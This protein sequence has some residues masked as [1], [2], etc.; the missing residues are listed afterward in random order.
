MSR[1]SRLFVSS[2]LVLS[3]APA[4]WSQSQSINGSISGRALDP[5]GASVAGATITVANSAV[6]FSKTVT[7]ANDGF[8]TLANLP[9][10]TYTVKFEASGFANLTVQNVVLNAGTQADING[11]L[12]VG[13]AGEEVNVTASNVG[14]DP[15]NL[16]V[17]RTLDSREVE[18]MPLTSRNPYNYIIFQPGVSGHPNPELG[19]PRTINTNGL[20]D[21]INYQ[22]DGMANTESDRTGLR[23]F[24]IGNIFVKEVQT[25]S[26]SANPEFGWTTGDVYNVISNNGTNQ[27]HGLL[28]YLQRWQTATAYPLLSNGGIKPDLQLRDFSGNIGGPIIKDKLFFFG[29]YEQIKRGIP[30]P[31]TINRNIATEIG[32]G[33]DQLVDAPGMLNGKFALG[34]LDWTINSKNQ[35]MLRYNYFINDFPYNTQVGGLNAHSVGSNFKDRAHV[36]GFQLIS[37]I[38]DHLVNEF[39]ATLPLRSS[40][41]V[42]AVPSNAPTI[43]ITNVATFGASPAGGDI[44]FEKQPSGS[45]NIS[46]TRGKHDIK[47]GFVLSAVQQR[48]RSVSYNQYTFDTKDAYLLAKN[49]TNLYSYSKFTSQTDVTGVGYASLFMGGYAQD[50]FRA[51][52]KLVLMGGLRWDRFKS[53]NA[54]PNAPYPDSRSFRSPGG[55]FSPRFGLSYRLADK[56]IFKASAGTFYQ[57]TPTN[58]WYSALNFDGSN[59]LDTY[60]YTPNQAGAPSFPNIPSTTETFAQQDVITVSPKFKNEY[61][62][63]INAKIT[64]QLSS[65]DSLTVGYI[66][67]NG[68]N[69]MYLH[70]INLQNP[71]GVLADGRPVFNPDLNASRP[72]PRFGQ[73]NRAESGANSS[74]NALVVNYTLTP[75]RGLQLNANYTWSH[76]IT[77]APEVYTFEQSV[78]ISDTTNRKRDRGNSY[79]NRP[80][81]FNMTAVLEPEFHFNS[82]FGNTLANS[83]RLA[84]LANMSSG[85][86][87]NLIAA[88]PTNQGYLSQLN[89]DKSTSSVQRPA[90]VGRNTYHSPN[91]YQI[92]ARYTRTFGTYFGRL[93]PSFLL[94]A[95]NV[96]NHSNV[97][98]LTLTQQVY[99]FNPSLTAA[100]NARAG[101]PS[102]GTIK[103]TRSTVL[104]ARIVQ[105]GVAVRF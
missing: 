74:F 64:Q 30:S 53:P 78:N 105:W 20:L 48:Q 59:R 3:A 52:P 70:N 16:N 10:G 58:L 43:V 54:N 21:R 79:V 60:T 89:G 91:I 8:Y 96:F 92:D 49:G 27:F 85:D 104:E 31:V 25:V 76:T 51:T 5:S 29:S 11:D 62:W 37:T 68:R 12:R 67:S 33:S 17:E 84:I 4:A 63:N 47:A 7:T 81:A 9:L 44:Y 46:Y 101:L 65:H 41:H 73:V 90:F 100:Q 82:R 1:L 97:T 40:S 93:Q 42:A 2:A 72:D 83:N 50:T 39:R 45:E 86:A 14:I 23:L 77:D 15:T 35:A 102:D 22:M 88:V 19:I 87:A 18:N 94:E 66:L 26:N 13:S 71:I 24:P 61:T 98:G 75:V 99:G 56:T 28:Q 34:R 6:G 55:N 38:N 69:L 57:S 103:T 32:L 80:S 36:F 95:N